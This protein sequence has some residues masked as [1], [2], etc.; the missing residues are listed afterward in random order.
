[1]SN[2]T[3][4]GELIPSIGFWGLLAMWVG[5]NIGGSLFA[6][7]S[8]AAGLSGPA[9]PIAML[10]S[11]LPALLAVLPYSILS[12]SQ[13]TTCG[14]YRYAQMVHPTMALVV[15]LSLTICILIGAQPLF[16]L[17][18]GS[19]LTHIA[20]V[21]PIAV[22]VGVLTFFYIINLLGISLAT[23]IQIIMFVLLMA[24][25]FIFIVTGA[26]HVKASNFNTLFPMGAGG[27][28][29]AAGLLFTFCTG[30]FFIIDLGGEVIT[31][32]RIF[33]RVLLLGMI[34][35]IALY[36]MILVISVGAVPW[37]WLEGKSLIHVAEQFMSRPALVFF[38]VGGAL[39]ACAT[40]I[41]GI[42]A[43]ASRGIMVLAKDG[44]LPEILGRVHPRF[45]SPYWGLT[46]CWLICVVSLVTIPS[47]MFFGS[48]LNL[49]LILAIT[50]VSLAGLV[51]PSRL[52][53]MFSNASIKVS[54][55]LNKA[56]CI[57]II[58][59]NTLI[60]FFFCVAIGKAS[61][62]FFGIVLLSMAY[63][64]LQRKR[65]QSLH[66]LLK[67]EPEQWLRRLRGE[68]ESNRG[69]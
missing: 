63:A 18:F 17:A 51:L 21:H 57:A 11:A 39:G 26:P 45:G 56:V 36:L 27:V 8:L 61:F 33:P 2:V 5:L 15:M 49:G 1:M 16:G 32:R 50:V 55:T 7:T 68:T 20:P 40:T 42:F 3:F 58:I 60:F 9:L 41:N 28:F 52:P 30:G 24:T 12:S 13:P 69:K 46:L 34:L 14:S 29:A 65:I 4:N 38:I 10:I 6:L 66:Q 37:E 47:L 23:R 54:G 67:S 48:M 43:I 25:L 22:G 59:L 53:G 64:V 35:V 62:V 44:L 31:A 19:F